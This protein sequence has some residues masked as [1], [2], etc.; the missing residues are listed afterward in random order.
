[1][2]HAKSVAAILALAAAASAPAR[3]DEGAPPECGVVKVTFRLEDERLRRSGIEWSKAEKRPFSESLVLAAALEHRED[4]RVEVR[5]RFGGVVVEARRTFGEEAAAGEV[6]AVVDSGEVAGARGARVAARAEREAAAASLAAEREATTKSLAALERLVAEGRPLAEEALRRVRDLAKEGLGTERERLEV[7]RAFLAE[8]L[9]AERDLALATLEARTRLAA[10]E[11]AARRAAAEFLAA[12]ARLAALGF[13][14]ED[15]RALD[16]GA[17]DG[18]VEIRSPLA[19][20]VLDRAAA[21]G[22]TVEEGAT[23]FVVA[24][25]SRLVAVGRAPEREIPLLEPGRP[26]GIVVPAHPG[27]V[28]KGKVLSVGRALDPA[29]RTASVRVLVGN[30]RGLLR[31][32]MLGSASVEVR[33][34]GPTLAVPTAAVQSDGCCRIVF[35]RKREGVVGVRRVRPGLEA[36]GWTEVVEGLAEGE[37]VIGRGAFTL[38]AEMLKAKFGSGC[39]DLE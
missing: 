34:P 19:G 26:A 24:D 5:A 12:D 32:G 8:T 35:V 39:C 14:P 33:A 10:A 11:S 3:A 28:F 18:R 21:P 13:T 25:D 23:L 16:S 36:E 7:E 4:A 22:A 9:G 30:S 1:M 17:F 29:T 37:E 38:K 6:L 15:R 31:A 2:T 20:V 27:R